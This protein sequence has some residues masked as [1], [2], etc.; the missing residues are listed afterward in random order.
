MLN[1]KQYKKY[2]LKTQKKNNILFSKNIIGLLNYRF[3]F[4][5]IKQIES[6]RKLIIR[7]LKKIVTVV[8][9]VHCLLPITKKATGIRMGKGSGPIN[10]YIC[11]IKPG[12]VFLE[13]FN[14][15]TKLLKKVL[16]Q[17]QKKINLSICILKRSFFFKINTT[18]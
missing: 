5:T 12:I 6:I 11:Y 18:K 8:I 7:K 15:E 2:S 4:I 14:L 16:K 3:D 9:K 10:N 1:K 17:L 13:F